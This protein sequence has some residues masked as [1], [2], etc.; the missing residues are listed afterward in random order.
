MIYSAGLTA[1]D[2]KLFDVIVQTTR[3]TR[4][5]TLDINLQPFLDD[6][7]SLEDIH[8][9]LETINTLAEEQAGMKH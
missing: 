8:Q 6:G 4:S 7:Y 3:E 5:K 2:R 1:L 9:S